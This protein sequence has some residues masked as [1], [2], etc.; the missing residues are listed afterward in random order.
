M[1]I[2]TQQ[3]APPQHRLQQLRPAGAEHAAARCGS[4]RRSCASAVAA[5]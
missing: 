1:S 2:I 4:A 3:A 5:L